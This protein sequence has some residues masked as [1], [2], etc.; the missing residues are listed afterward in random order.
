M[1]KAITSMGSMRL[2]ARRQTYGSA[3]LRL[4]VRLF[5]HEMQ[6][7]LAAVVLLIGVYTLFGENALFGG[8][9][10]ILGIG[11]YGGADT[12][13]YFHI[14][15]SSWDSGGDGGGDGGGGGD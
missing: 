2:R 11:I 3:P 14:D 8:I 15:L 9:L 10:V 6:K 12:G 1:S 7:F 5:T 13:V 4:N